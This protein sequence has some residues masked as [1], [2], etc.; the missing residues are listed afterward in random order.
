MCIYQ[1]NNPEQQSDRQRS[2]RGWRSQSRKNIV[3]F[4]ENQYLT[5]LESEWVSEREKKENEDESIHSWIQLIKSNLALRQARKYHR[6]MIETVS[7]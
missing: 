5:E 1:H 4:H 2:V 7:V 3:L 6:P